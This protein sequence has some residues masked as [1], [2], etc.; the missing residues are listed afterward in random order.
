MND[1]LIH[2]GV[3]G[4]KWGRRKPKN[5]SAPKKGKSKRQLKLEDEYQ[6]QG[7]TKAQSETAARKRIKTEKILAVTAGVTIAA[8]GAYAGYRYYNN[9]VDKFIKSGTTLQ[10]INTFGDRGVSDAFYASMNKKD[11][12]KY[13][14]FYANQLRDKANPFS[15]PK[16]VF[17]TDIQVDK[18]LKLA[19]RKNSTKAVEELLKN[20]MDFKKAVGDRLLTYA[21]YGTNTKQKKIANKAFENIKKGKIDA[22]VHDA[23][24]ITL[25]DRTPAGMRIK[26]KLFNQLK[27]KGYDAIV[28]VNDKHFS[29]YRSKNPLIV[30]NGAS[31][32]KVKTFRKLNDDEIFKNITRGEVR[33]ISEDLIKKAALW[34][35]GIG[36]L[37]LGN[38]VYRENSRRKG[39]TLRNKSKK[40]KQNSVMNTEGGGSK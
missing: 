9:T 18:A 25:V 2:Y 34:T 15:I 3:L 28:D 36:A 12:T 7:L 32:T 26:S 38:R 8:L 31:K 22:T 24:N 35:A 5:T 11:N 1:E 29:G 6:K 39:L 30:F 21:K 23:I 33:M 20:D 17:K 4:M 16:T 14:G 37:N 40:E 27:N 13:A 19:S 10:N